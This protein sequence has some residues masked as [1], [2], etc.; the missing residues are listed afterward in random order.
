[1]AEDSTTGVDFQERLTEIIN[2]IHAA[3]SIRDIILNQ[4]PKLIELF[5]TDRVTVYSIDTRTN[6]LFSLFKEGS[7]VNE[8]RVPRNFGSISGF[9]ATAN[10]TANIR[11]AYDADELRGY[12]PELTFDSR[13][14]KKTGF[15]TRQVLV[16]PIAHNKHVLGVLQLVNK[17]SGDA[18]SDED[19]SATKKIA[20]TLGIAFFNQRRMG[21]AAKPNK[22]GYLLDA[23]LVSEKALEEAVTYARINNRPIATVLMEKCRV[24]KEELLKSLGEYYSTP[25]FLYDGAQLM[26]EEYR[27]RF[28][29]ERLKKLR[30]APISRTDGAVR[31]A[32]EDPSDLE[33]VDLVRIMNLGPTIEYC[34]ALGEDIEA[35]LTASYG[36]AEDDQAQL[37]DE[38][39]GELALE[40]ETEEDAEPEADE[41]DSTI[42]R[43]A[44][45]MI[46]DAV[47][48]GASDIHVEPYGDRR[49]TLIRFRVDG[50]CHVHL[51]VPPGHRRALIS[52]LKIMANLDIAEKRKPQDG[53]IRFHM[54]GKL[55]ELRVATIPTTGGEEDV[56]MRILAASEPIPLDNMYLS[57]R[58]LHV[59]MEMA[60]KPYGILLCVGPT[61]SGKTTTLHSLLGFINMPDRKIWTAEDPVEITQRGLRQVEVKPKIGFTFAAAMRSFLRADP[62]VIMVGEM[63]DKET[64]SIGVEAS[65]TG[66]LVL[67]TLHTNSAPETITR[68]LEMDIDPFNFADALIGVL[69][70]RLVRTLCK[71]CKEEY[72]APQS[73]VDSLI[74]LYG[75]DDFASSDI[76]L[77]PEQKLYRPVGCKLCG[78]TG[79]RGR[80]ALH[81]LLDGTEELKHQ[82]LRG[83][84]VDELRRQAKEDGMTTL[85]QDG[86][87]KVLAGYTDINQVRAVCLK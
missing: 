2:E 75:L 5:N 10:Q 31:V 62:D 57:E 84:R 16:T 15:R 20:T 49:S 54:G 67:S 23:G 1:M 43:A 14:D 70:Q 34:V 87:R 60:R 18:F 77:V 63:R 13:W 40:D 12:H 50:A 36:V 66:H 32:L 44:S 86:I 69:A 28:A 82:I 72:V 53:K 33:K 30:V 48:Q 27:E 80:M 24:P 64:A 73:E 85:M 56:V 71:E 55:V 9:C 17:R 81:E 47:L 51:E 74:K 68:L 7:D 4:T 42:V 35:F 61:G 21:R 3:D 22:F 45:Q 38:I 25:Y 26:P 37:L 6:Q 83:A 39:L 52:R 11:D 41:S 76:E 58:N 8:I 79:F 59:L 78:G 29:F 65:L 19:I 46:K